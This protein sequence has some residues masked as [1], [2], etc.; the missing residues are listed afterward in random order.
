VLSKDVVVADP[1]QTNLVLRVAILK[2]VVA[3]IA[4]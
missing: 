3:M 1:T 2:G 4:T